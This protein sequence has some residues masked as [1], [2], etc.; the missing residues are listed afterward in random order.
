MDFLLKH[1]EYI[2]TI[3]V[4]PYIYSKHTQIDGIE[5]I[6]FKEK[7]WALEFDFISQK[8]NDF[9]SKKA[10]VLANGF[11]SLINQSKPEWTH[12][13]YRMYSSWQ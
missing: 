10:K 9:N 7:D 12:P 8:Q 1:S 11:E 2:D 4:S 5:Q 6:K 3:D 13:I